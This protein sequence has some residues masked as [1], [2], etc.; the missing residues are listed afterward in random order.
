MLVSLGFDTIS[1]DAVFWFASC[2]ALVAVVVGYVLDAIMERVS[3]GVV[4]NAM[5]L[6]GGVL[7]G[8]VLANAFYAPLRSMHAM[9]FAFVCVGSGFGLVLLL[10]L[11]RRLAG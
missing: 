2:L 3:F 11:V 4:A 8:I 7:G 5:L 1:W 9:E 6:W 10:G